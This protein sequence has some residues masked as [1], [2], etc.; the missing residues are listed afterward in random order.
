T[1]ELCNTDG[2]GP[3]VTST[4]DCG[5][6]GDI[7]KDGKCAPLLEPKPPGD[8]IPC[9]N[10]EGYVCEGDLSFWCSASGFIDSISEPMDCAFFG[11][12]CVD[13]A[14]QN[15]QTVCDPNTPYCDGNSQ[16]LCNAQ[17]TG[18]EYSD[19]CPAATVCFQSDPDATPTC[20]AAD[21]D[22]GG[23]C[24]GLECGYCE[25]QWLWTCAPDPAEQNGCVEET[26]L[27]C[28]AGICSAKQYNDS[29]FPDN[30]FTDWEAE[31]TKAERACY[32]F[33]LS[34]STSCGFVS[35]TQEHYDELGQL[36]SDEDKEGGPYDGWSG[37]WPLTP[38]DSCACGYLNGACEEGKTCHDYGL[39]IA[40]KADE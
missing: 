25:G 3:E 38:A 21:D 7:C 28:D 9:D 35:P 1:L 6:T 30:C 20:I 29:W 19:P 17:G 39:M 14:C 22:D 12:I 13:G 33:C 24:D 23:S 26:D 2:D 36:Q 15:G 16:A 8:G 31:S 34:M 11:Q 37:I 40:C 32:Y 4:V 27:W 10:P 18:N 5:R